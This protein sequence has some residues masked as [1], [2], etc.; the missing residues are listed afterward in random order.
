MTADI[1]AQMLARYR[2]T[3]TQRQQRLDVRFTAAWAVAHMGAA[4]LKDRYGVD[5]V[6]VFGSLLSRARFY[7]R[8]DIDLAVKQ[9]E[10]RDYFRAVSA[11]LDL[12]P[13]F[14]FDLVEI[15]F[16]PSALRDA[17]MHEGVQL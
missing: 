17:I 8:S 7:E 10:G 16:A 2:A 6:W 9:I 3:A 14:S 13:E 1:P 15:D 11:L 4:L 5:D 12:T